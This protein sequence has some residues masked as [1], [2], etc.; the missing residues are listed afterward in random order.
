M[1]DTLIV[2]NAFFTCCCSIDISH[3]TRWTNNQVWLVT[4]ALV[5]YV[6]C[7]RW[8]ENETISPT[9]PDA[10]YNTGGERVWPLQIVAD[11]TSPLRAHTQHRVG[12]CFPEEAYFDRRGHRDF[13]EVPQIEELVLP[14][15][16]CL[17]SKTNMQRQLDEPFV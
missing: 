11:G 7:T 16:K 17:T 3:C 6:Y 12:Y 15:K 13:S 8:T 1:G 14:L 4:A 5:F 9:Q 10:V 2:F